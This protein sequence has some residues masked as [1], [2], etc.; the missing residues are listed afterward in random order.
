[1]TYEVVPEAGA[2]FERLGDRISSHQWPGPYMIYM[3]CN[4]YGKHVGCGLYYYDD[5]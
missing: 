4:G 1:M 5:V 3:S 2:A